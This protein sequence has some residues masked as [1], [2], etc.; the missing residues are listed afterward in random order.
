MDKS[1]KMK[2]IAAAL[3]SKKL[4]DDSK[5]NALKNRSNPFVD[6]NNPK[7]NIKKY[8]KATNEPKTGGMNFGQL[9]QVQ[10]A[11]KQGK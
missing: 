2:A 9:R 3:A 7:A 10:K 11:K 8:G 1:K 6:I 5:G 4:P